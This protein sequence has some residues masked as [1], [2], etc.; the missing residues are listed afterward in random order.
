MES[1]FKNRKTYQLTKDWILFIRLFIN[2]VDLACRLFDFI[3]IHVASLK[4]K[5]GLI[6][7]NLLEAKLNR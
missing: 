3:I 2:K 4:A 5:E 6:L 1:T 7:L